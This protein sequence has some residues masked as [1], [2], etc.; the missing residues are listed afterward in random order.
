M[1]ESSRLLAGNARFVRVIGKRN[2]ATTSSNLVPLLTDGCSFWRLFPHISCFRFSEWH[3][4]NT[5]THCFRIF[6]QHKR[7]NHMIQQGLVPSWTKQFTNPNQTNASLLLDLH[8]LPTHSLEH[9]DANSIHEPAIRN[10]GSNIWEKLFA[11]FDLII[12][13][14][15]DVFCSKNT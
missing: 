13:F 10:T 12:A 9:P 1:N 7:G 6:G 8:P 5:A 14:T 2:L 15:Q 3:T 4:S 11:N